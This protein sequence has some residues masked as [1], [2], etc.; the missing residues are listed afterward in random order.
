MVDAVFNL[1]RPNGVV[2]KVPYFQ[3]WPLSSSMKH[4]DGDMAVYMYDEEMVESIYGWEGID[5]YL[6]FMVWLERIIWV[7]QVA[8]KLM[9]LKVEMVG[10]K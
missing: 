1:A 6:H 8:T 7:H 5:S 9:V 3:I 4:F 10:N 2:W